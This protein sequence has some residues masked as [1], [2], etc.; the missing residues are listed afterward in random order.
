MISELF[1]HKK[2]R[3]LVYL[4]FVVNIWVMFV[5]WLGGVL[6]GVDAQGGSCEG[7]YQR[8]SELAFGA[9]VASLIAYAV[10]QL[11]DVTI[12]H[13]S[14][15][16]TGHHYLWVR[17]ILSTSAGQLLDTITVILVTHYYANALPIDAQKPLLNQ[18][19]VYVASGYGYKFIC[20]VLDTSLLYVLIPHL[21]R[22]C[23]LSEQHQDG[24]A[25]DD[26][27]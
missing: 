4:G 13:W 7:V 10:A 5:I 8:I 14:R 18:I 3:L 6:P 24:E 25:E 22:Y 11:A 19:V 2:A 16:Q 15:K 20:G 26:F 27:N 17:S 12:F 9:V 23:F 21:R 1:G